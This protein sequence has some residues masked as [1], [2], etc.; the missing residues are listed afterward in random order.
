MFE[1]SDDEVSYGSIPLKPL[2]YQDDIFRATTT[3]KGAQNGLIKI[4]K[5]MG[6]KQLEVHPDKTG[7]II[8][9]TN[10]KLNE[11]REEIEKGYGRNA[12]YQIKNQTK[13]IIYKFFNFILT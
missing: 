8:L 4:S 7:H 13:L 9:A 12:S 2:L 5:V 1:T 6:L 3:V 10:I 11:I